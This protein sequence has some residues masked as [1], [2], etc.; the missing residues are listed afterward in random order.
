MVAQRR[1]PVRPIAGEITRAWQRQALV[2]R[3]VKRRLVGNVTNGP[4]PMKGRAT[5]AHRAFVVHHT[6][7]GGI[8]PQHSRVGE[9]PSRFR[10]L[11]RDKIDHP[12]EGDVRQAR[13]IF[14][15]AAADI[16]MVAKGGSRRVLRRR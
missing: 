12:M 15:I 4:R 3:F 1:R 7:A 6:I 8:E 11:L 10:D 5:D 14:G 16:G 2:N 9:Y 13:F